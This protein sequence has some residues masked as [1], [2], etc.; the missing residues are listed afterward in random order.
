MIQGKYFL[1]RN[2]WIFSLAILFWIGTASVA[3]PVTSQTK[4]SL[5]SPD[6]NLMVDFWQNGIEGKKKMYYQVSFKNKPVILESALDIQLD[7]HLSQLALALKVDPADS[8]IGD[9]MLEKAEQSSHDT[10]W[11]PLYGE[12][13]QIRDHYNALTLYFYKASDPRYKINLII[14]A[15]NEGV[16]FRYYFPDNPT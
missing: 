2:K 12:R 5:S 7:N 9:L 1:S 16:A 10:L 15:Y 3:Q 8:W 4:K 11:R 13:S 14:R 6:G